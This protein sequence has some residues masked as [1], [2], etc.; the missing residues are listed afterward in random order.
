MVAGAFYA[1]P[2]S[3]SSCAW[4]PVVALV[5][6]LGWFTVAEAARSI[7]RP[8]GSRFLPGGAFS[9]VDGRRSRVAPALHGCAADRGVGDSESAS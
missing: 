4:E 8:G 6:A 2:A 7:L 3:A 1:G 9:V 5:V